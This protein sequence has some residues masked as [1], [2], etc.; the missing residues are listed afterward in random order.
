MKDFSYFI[1][2]YEDAAFTR[3]LT[4]KVIEYGESVDFSF[5]VKIGKNEGENEVLLDSTGFKIIADEDI[6]SIR[7]DGNKIDVHVDNNE[8]IEDLSNVI[9][10]VPL[11]YDYTQAY[12]YVI[13]KAN[14]FS[15][16]AEDNVTLPM[17]QSQTRNINISISGGTERFKIKTI[18][19][20]LSDG[21]FT[22]YDNGLIYDIDNTKGSQK[23]IIKSN[24]VPFLENGAYYEI[25]VC[26]EEKLVLPLFIIDND[27][28]SEF[29]GT[30][31]EDPNFEEK[32]EQ[33][34][35]SIKVTYGGGGRSLPNRHNIQNTK[36]QTLNETQTL[37]FSSNGETKYFP[38]IGDTVEFYYN[39]SDD[40]DWC[41]VNKRALNYSIMCDIN[42]TYEE[43]ECQCEILGEV[44]N[45]R[46]N[47]KQVNI[48]KNSTNKLGLK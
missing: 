4:F 20:Y 39:I 31:I 24:G 17:F 15:V 1:R 29:Y 33:L 41:H 23:I 44:L 18:N 22:L 12:V 32:E 30:Y 9:N 19:K 3:E 14:I 28:S 38:L 48:V 36:P 34:T 8:S 37:F 21:T 45:I 26:H 10:I 7:Q 43:R 16:S 25:V 46:Q 40:I 47:A 5:Y 6:F 35:H 2:A 42:D 27:E 13:Q 11:L